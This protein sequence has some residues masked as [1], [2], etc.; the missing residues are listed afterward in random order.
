MKGV[1]Y[2]AYSASRGIFLSELIK[3]DLWW[4]GP[5]WLE[6]SESHWPD[7]PILFDHPESVK[8]K[9]DE[10]WVAVITTKDESILERFS[11]YTRLKRVTAWIF[12]FNRN[13]GQPKSKRGSTFSG[14]SRGGSMEPPF[15]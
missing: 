5:E 4:K 8:E 1:D 11:D 12:K 6:L 2:Q 15:L 14:G 3:H 7:Q 10:L 9:G 13:C